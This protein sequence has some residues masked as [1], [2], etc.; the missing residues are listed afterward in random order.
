MKYKMEIFFSINNLK[1][2]VKM[3]VFE[4]VA[5]RYLTVANRYYSVSNRYV[6]NR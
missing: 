3:F 2:G 6:A 5:N 4:H 1:T